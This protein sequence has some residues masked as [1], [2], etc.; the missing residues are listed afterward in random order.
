MPR[1]S[2]PTTRTRI[3]SYELSSTIRSHCYSAQKNAHVYAWPYALANIGTFASSPSPASYTGSR[4]L[5]F[6]ADKAQLSPASIPKAQSHLSKN[7]RVM[8]STMTPAEESGA[9]LPTSTADFTNPDLLL[10]RSLFFLH[11]YVL[12]VISFLSIPPFGFS[13]LVLCF[14]FPISFLDV[15]TAILLPD[16]A[17]S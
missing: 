14:P 16:P 2:S 17:S 1:Q 8:Q 12:N 3:S 4:T 6:F 5:S 13:F 15:H 10:S 7:L 11:T 9:C